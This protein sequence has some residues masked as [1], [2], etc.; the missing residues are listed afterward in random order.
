MDNK[1]KEIA[2][3]ENPRANEPA[4]TQAHHIMQTSAAVE[5]RPLNETPEQA[6]E[7]KRA[8]RLAA[9]IKNNPVVFWT[10]TKDVNTI[11]T[12]DKQPLEVLLTWKE[13][14]VQEAIE[15]YGLTPLDY[16]YVP[17]R[18]NSLLSRIAVL[19]KQIVNA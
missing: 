10:T 13:M 7:N 2:R 15:Q 17:P 12:V 1:L 9:F 16:A 8:K 19:S 5:E 11:K 3:I 14:Y 18:K 6:L 4:P